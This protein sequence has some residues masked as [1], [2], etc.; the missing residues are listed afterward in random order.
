VDNTK[1]LFMFTM[2]CRW[3]LYRFT[4]PAFLHELYWGK[5][6]GHHVRLLGFFFQ[7]TR[8]KCCKR[9]FKL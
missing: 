1:D 8:F 7:E 6:E 4:D 5:V 3:W 2:T 9:T